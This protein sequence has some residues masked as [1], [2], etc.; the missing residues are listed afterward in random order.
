MIREEKYKA[1][2][3]FG[4]KYIISKKKGSTGNARFYVMALEDVSEGSFQ[5]IQ[6]YHDGSYYWYK[7]AR[8]KINIINTA[9]DFG[10]GYNNTKVTV[11]IW[12]KNGTGEGSYLGATQDE[13]DI[14]GHIQEEYEK[15][16]YIPSL[17]EWIAFVHFFSTKNIII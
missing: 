13:H 15:G 6:G 9:L 1:N 12:N 17:G 14:W 7:N 10:Q 5:G 2:D 16:W 3:G 11:E 8:D 4:E